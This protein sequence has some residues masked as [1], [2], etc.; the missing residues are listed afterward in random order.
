MVQLLT[1]I[2]LCVYREIIHPVC[3]LG[4]F[5][6]FESVCSGCF[7][8]CQFFLIY[9]TILLLVRKTVVTMKYSIG[10]LQQV[11]TLIT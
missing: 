8:T 5:E 2:H 11:K 6:S 1:N 7:N 9:E 3:V 4:F 10:V